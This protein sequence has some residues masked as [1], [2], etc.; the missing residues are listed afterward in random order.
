MVRA[1]GIKLFSH[2]LVAEDNFRPLVPSRAWFKEI[3]QANRTV[4][5]VH[6]LTDLYA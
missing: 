5:L 2:N 6:C 4:R 3:N 1:S